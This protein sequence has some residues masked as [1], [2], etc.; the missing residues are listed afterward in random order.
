MAVLIRDMEMPKS[1]VDCKVAV[2]VKDGVLCTP[3][4]RIVKEK[5]LSERQQ[6][7]PLIEVPTPHGRLIIEDGEIVNE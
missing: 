3:M 1:C 4:F 5:I 7:C 6:D 2:A